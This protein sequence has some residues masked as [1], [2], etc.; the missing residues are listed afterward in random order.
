MKCI[1]NCYVFN[2][3]EIA[4]PIEAMVYMSMGWLK[5]LS[6]PSTV[7]KAM[8]DEKVKSKCI[9]MSKKFQDITKILMEVQKEGA[10]PKD[11]SFSPPFDVDFSEQICSITPEELFHDFAYSASKVAGK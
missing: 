3:D 11:S 4:Y 2:K 10:W 1:N 5:M 8:A 7:D 9:Q 6:S